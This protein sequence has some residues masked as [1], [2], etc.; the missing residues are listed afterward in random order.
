MAIEKFD[1][2]LDSSRDICPTIKHLAFRRGDG[3]PLDFIPGQFITF[4]FEVDGK[5]KRR[6]YSVATIPGQSDLI[7]IAVSYVEN[8]IA[9]ERL[10]GMKPGDQFPAMGPAGRLILQ[11]DGMK[12]YLLVGTGTGIAPYRA[13]L[14]A[15]AE[16]MA[17]DEFSVEVVMGARHRCDLLYQED[18]LDFQK[19]QPNF[20]YHAHL[21]REDLDEKAEGHEQA[22]Y[23]Q[24]CF[25]RL[26]IKPGEDVI[27]LCGNP[28][29]IDEC[30]AELQSR[31]FDKKDIRREKYISS[32]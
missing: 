28:D 7:E 26:N 17:G 11:E 10:F 21:S 3:M 2:V 15:L 5:T 9:T 27:Y 12:R 31:G 30:F 32:N 22:G 25:D 8:G 13:M 23:V 14:P 6:S 19:Q 4:L 29:M 16:R 1:L 20:H 18:F 24:T